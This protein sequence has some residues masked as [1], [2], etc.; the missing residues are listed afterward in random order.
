MLVKVLLYL[1]LALVWVGLTGEVTL[2]AFVTGIII[3]IIIMKL[4]GERSLRNLHLNIRH[5]RPLIQL[6][7]IFCWISNLC[8]IYRLICRYRF[9]ILIFIFHIALYS[10]IC[11]FCKYLQR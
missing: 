7:F 6:F 1:V 11:L 5:F 10:V 9:R 3:G 8:L 2:P 4:Y